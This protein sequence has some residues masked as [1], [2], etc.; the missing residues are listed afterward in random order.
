MPGSNSETHGSYCD[1]L[2]SNI[3]VQYS[4]IT[5]H[6]GITAREY[7]DRLCNQVHPMIQTLFPNNDAVFPDDSAPHSHSWSWFEEHES[8]LHHLPWSAHSSDFNMIEPFWLVLGTRVRNR[9]QI[10][11]SLKQL[12]DVLQEEWYKISLE[13]VKNLCESIPRRTVV[14]LMA[15]VAQHMCIVSLVLP[16]FCSTVWGWR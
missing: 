11:K 15:K 9:I 2:G 16:L 13:T 12:E 1:G 5:L 14:V 10:P 7:V 6:G 3:V 4:V 8:E